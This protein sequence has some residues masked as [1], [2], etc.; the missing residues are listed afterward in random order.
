[1]TKGLLSSCRNELDGF[2]T[3]LRIDAPQFVTWIIVTG[4]EFGRLLRLEL[5]L[6]HDTLV[7]VHFLLD[8]STLL[9]V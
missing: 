8:F 9:G 2:Q 6:V 3:S 4:T 1:M 5:D 7:L